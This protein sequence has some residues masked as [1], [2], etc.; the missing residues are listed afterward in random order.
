MLL[1]LLAG[2]GINA[3]FIGDDSLSSR[4]MN[5][6]LDPLSQMGLVSESNDGKLPITINNSEL[7]GIHYESKVA[8]AK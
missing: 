7:T 4:P 6:I 2:Q 5:R 1:G 3:T 8:S